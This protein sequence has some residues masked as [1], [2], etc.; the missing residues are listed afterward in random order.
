MI[1]QG[2]WQEAEYL[3][4]SGI[5]HFIYC[6][7]R[8][9]LIHIEQAWEE[10]YF[11]THGTLLHERVDQ[12]NIKEKRR[13]TVTIRAMTIASYRLGMNGVCDLVEFR[14]DPQGVYIP[15]Y[16]GTYIPHPVEYKRGKSQKNDSDRYQLLA[17][18]MS[19]EEM[20]SIELSEAS[21]FYHDVRRRTSYSF[22][23]ED[24][25]HLMKIAEEMHTLYSRGYTPKPKISQKCR[26]CSLKNICLPELDQ[27]K[28]ASTYIQERLKECENS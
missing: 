5:R 2:R 11:T 17:Q 8:W 20:L 10:N 13:A 22:S 21:I 14:K 26:S 4:I 23:I 28:I 15:Q 25:E 24:K 18:L 1:G 16:S 19:L 12:P 6:R 3:M 7:R 9:A 27:V